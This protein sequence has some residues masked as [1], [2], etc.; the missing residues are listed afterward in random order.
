MDKAQLVGVASI[1]SSDAWATGV[2]GT[3]FGTPFFERWNGSSWTVSSTSSL[4]TE[5]LSAVSSSLVWAVGAD[6]GPDPDQHIAT[7]RWNGSTWQAVGVPLTNGSLSDVS[8]PSA[9]TA[10]SVGYRHVSYGTTTAARTLAL[11]WDGSTWQTTST[12]NPIREDN[13][14]LGVSALSANVAWAV[15]YVAPFGGHGRPLIMVHC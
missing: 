7:Q 6:T 4:F 15:G 9:T 10:W 2:A 13:V 5:A 14:L 3:Y 1:G 11:T 8:A 12:P